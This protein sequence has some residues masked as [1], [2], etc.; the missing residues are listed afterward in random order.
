[1][2]D[3]NNP[4]ILEETSAP[5]NSKKKKIVNLVTVAVLSAV[6]IALCIFSAVI[7]I[8]KCGA[9]T[10]VASYDE[11]TKD[12][13]VIVTENEKTDPTTPDGKVYTAKQDWEELLKIN[14]EIKAWVDIPGTRV[15]YPVLKHEGDGYGSQYY[16]HRNYDLSYTFAG[17]IFIDYRSTQGVNSKNI[18]THGHKMNNGTMYGD[19]I[20]Y[21]AYEGDLEYF[22]EH[23]TVFFNTPEGG[24]EQWMII[25][26]FKTN[27]L[28]AHGDFFNYF[29]GEFSSDAQFMNYVYN[30]KIRSLF[31]IDV[32][33][34]EDDQLLVL[35]TCSHE[36]TDFRT[37]I[38]ARK[39]RDGE[40]VI[41]YVKSAKLAENPVWPEVYYS[42]HYGTRPEV[43]SFKTELQKGNID[44]YD[45]E[46]KLTGSEWLVTVE[47]NSSYSVTFLDW[48]GSILST[49]TVPQGHDAVPPAD[50][51]RPDDDYYTYT[52]RCWQLDYTNVN[53]N[54]AIA[55]SYDATL[56]NQ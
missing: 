1:M 24:N 52:F 14:D 48:D 11:A 21:G 26:Y 10:S 31:D 5:N 6:L 46:G 50:P 35:S 28:N 15:N 42:D 37:V 2:E 25:S 43:T 41:P 36:Y 18:I 22:K 38:V 13:T 39:I 30:V 44:W 56:K 47:G 34:N 17:S 49:Q 9:D 8:D 27:T 40:T 54:M 55:P 32:P 53:R 20:K 51:V 7:L 4:V 19:L 45:G 16:L 29:M 12:E 23:P 33:V 3:M